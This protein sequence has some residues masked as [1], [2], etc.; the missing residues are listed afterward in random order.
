MSADPLVEPVKGRDEEAVA[1]FVERFA[2]LMTESGMQRMPARVFA[3]IMASEQGALTAAEISAQ[4]GIS[5][6]AVSG[7]VRYLTEVR[8]VRRDREPGQRRDVYRMG[9]EFWFD[10]FARKNR[11]MDDLVAAIRDGAEVLGA[12]TPAGDRMAHSAE[13]LSH[14]RQALTLLM[15]RWHAERQAR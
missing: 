7:A 9:D 2:L 14:M 1:Q 4:L 8:L 6:A 3:L 5:P 13:Y 15:E 11:A 12:G 10:V